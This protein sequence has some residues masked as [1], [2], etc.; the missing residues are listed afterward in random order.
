MQGK[1]EKSLFFHDDS[2]CDNCQPLKLGIVSICLSLMSKMVQVNNINNF[3][4]F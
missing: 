3:V 1:L 2:Q 4:L